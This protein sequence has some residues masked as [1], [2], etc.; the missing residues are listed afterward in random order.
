M[1]QHVPRTALAQEMADAMTGQVLFSDASNGLFL[2][3]PRRTGKSTFLQQDLAPIL[4]ARGVV[5]VYV[6][7]WADQEQSP[8]KLIREALVKALAPH[9]G[10]V[11][12]AAKA[13]GLTKVTVGAGAGKL[14]VDT[15]H[16][17]NLDTTTLFEAIKILHEAA[18]APVALI[19][20]EAQQAL[21]SANGQ[22]VMF[23]LKS[24]RDQLNGPG[25]P[26]LM[27]VMS[28]SDRDKLL[29]LVN[30]KDAPFYGSQLHEMPLLGAE[31]LAF[32][33]QRIRLQYPNR[34]VA[35]DKLAEAFACFN[36][37]PQPFTDALGQVLHPLAVPSDEPFE[38]RLLRLAHAQEE[39]GE[40]QMASD[41]LGLSLLD[42][43]VLWRVLEQGAKFRPYD[44][45]AL[46]FYAT[47]THTKVSVAQVQKALDRLR[48]RTPSLVWRSANGDY[49]ADDAAMQRWYGRRVSAGTWPPRRTS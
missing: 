34:S 21:A 10:R 49:A 18:K 3:A 46:A 22:A 48:D 39:E 20:D 7:L 38:D 15:T 31:F 28:G 4:T 25:A 27:L 12:R 37:R 41:F 19:V 16:L 2:A 36:H 29:R 14:E 47:H 23:A 40:Q 13:A 1:L 11:A 9:L 8:E 42:Q 6:D 30:R 35:G 44:A 26:T 24:A 32:V 45:N 43:A 17:G 33:V 5:V